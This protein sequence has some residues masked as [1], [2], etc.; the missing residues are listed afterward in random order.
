MTCGPFGLLRSA[1]P[2]LVLLDHFAGESPAFRDIEALL[3]RPGA[4]LATPFP[5]CQGPDGRATMGRPDQACVVEKTRQLSAKVGGM[6]GIQVDLVRTA[7]DA[8]LD[9]L[10]GWAASQVVLEAYID[11]LHYAPPTR[12]VLWLALLR[13]CRRRIW[14]IP[15]FRPI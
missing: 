8:E 10:V 2:A 12:R 14:V 9:C 4:Y 15:I 7:V 11:V 3:L 13:N 6:A 5:V 1:V